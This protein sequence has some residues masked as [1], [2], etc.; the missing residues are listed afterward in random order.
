MRWFTNL[1]I[2][3]KLLGGF[4]LVALLAGLVGAVGIQGVN[5]LDT[6]MQSVTGDT[7][8]SLLSLMRTQDDMDASIRF[9]RAVI[10]STVPADQ[11]GWAAKAQTYQQ[12]A[13]TDFARYFNAL[14]DSTS[15]E[16]HTAA[17]ARSHLARWA[18]LDAAAVQA[19]LVNTAASKARATEISVIG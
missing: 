3:V 2:A 17:D 15:D 14:T 10:L 11:R 12:A 5:T 16:A 4:A 13:L 7:V 6:S 19:G 1:S 8:P 9:S 18:S